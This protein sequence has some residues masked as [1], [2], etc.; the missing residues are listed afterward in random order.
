MTQCN[1]KHSTQRTIIWKL[2]ELMLAIFNHKRDWNCYYSGVYIEKHM[3]KQSSRLKT[4]LLFTTRGSG[5]PNWSITACPNRYV[6]NTSLALYKCRSDIRW[7]CCIR[8]AEHLLL[9]CCFVRSA[10]LVSRKR[11]W[12][13][14]CQTQD[15]SWLL[16]WG[17]ETAAEQC[18]QGEQ[19][20]LVTLPQHW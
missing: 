10:V 5:W 6:F 20:S 12:H 7:I 16:S 15:W 14:E 17:L 8:A 11:G 4:S 13:S 9:L 1:L 19:L 18:C 2:W 3:M